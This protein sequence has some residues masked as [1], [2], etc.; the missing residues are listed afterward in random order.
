[1]RA[2]KPHENSRTA[3]WLSRRWQPWLVPRTTE[4]TLDAPCERMPLSAQ[5]TF[6]FPIFTGL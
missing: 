1:M 3:R 2:M 4:V 5:Y 6:F